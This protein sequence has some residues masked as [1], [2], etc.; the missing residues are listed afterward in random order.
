MFP[1]IPTTYTLFATLCY[2]VSS[3]VL[4]LVHSDV[5]HVKI[6][7]RTKIRRTKFSADKNFRRTK[8]SAP[9]PIFGNFVRRKFLSAE[10]LSKPVLTV[11]RVFTMFSRISRKR[12]NN[13]LYF[14]RSYNCCNISVMDLDFWFYVLLRN[15]RKLKFPENP[16]ITASRMK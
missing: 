15:S 10:F 5:Y 9:S 4:L 3:S 1:D 8:F 7:Y 13:R 11:I 12:G 16:G 6:P 14:A 2:G